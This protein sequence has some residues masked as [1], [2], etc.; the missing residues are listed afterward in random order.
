MTLSSPTQAT[1]KIS[2]GNWPIMALGFRPFYLG[3]A[4][5]AVLALPLWLGWYSGA[6]SVQPAM[7]GFTWHMHEMIFGFA[8]AVIAGFLLTAVRNWTGRPTPTGTALAGLFLLWIAGRVLLL[9][10]PLPLAAIVDL[11]FLPAVGVAV[12]IPIWKSRNKRNFKVLAII[13][14]LTI[15][16]LTFHLSNLNILPNVLVITAY[17]LALDIIAILIAI[18]GG[19]VIPAFTSNALPTANV[20]RDPRVEFVAIGSLIVIAIAG[21]LSPWWAMPRG[22]WIVILALGALSHLIRVALWEP[23][24]TVSAPLLLMLPVAYAWL[25]LSLVLRMLAEFGVVPMPTA[26]HALTIG[27]MSSLMLA[28]MVRSALGHTGRPLLASAAEI[29]AFSLLQLSAIVRVFAYS[30]PAEFYRSAV[31]AAGAMWT[32]AFA[33][34]LAAYWPVLTRRRVDGRPG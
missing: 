22:V 29:L 31:M 10:G 11:M 16:N 34:F 18:M 23:H 2:A 8:P 26:V 3:A 9:T 27:A 21:L 6:L 17:K 24:R 19:R 33:I 20:R 30:I 13:A 1:G 7:N 5:F 14:A 12:A 28:M 32:A 25:P 15:A 4:I